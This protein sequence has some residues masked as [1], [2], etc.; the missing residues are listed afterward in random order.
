M[1]YITD[2]IYSIDKYSCFLYILSF[3]SILW[4]YEL[5]IYVARFKIFYKIINLYDYWLI[6]WCLYKMVVYKDQLDILL[7]NQL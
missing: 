2:F 6:K 1:N 3:L 5:K 7:L 4:K